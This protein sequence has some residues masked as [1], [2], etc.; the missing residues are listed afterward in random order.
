M[1]DQPAPEHRRP[2][3]VSDATIEALGKL[4]AAVDHVEHARGHLYAFHRLIGSA[5]RT[6]EEATDLL[7]DAGHDA[8]AADLD[9]KVL[10]R[11]P[12]PG[13]WTFQ[14]VEAFDDGYYAEATGLQQRAID[15]LVEGRRHIF[16]AEMKELRR[17]RGIEGHEAT[18]DDADGQI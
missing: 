9:R 4:S 5:E 8:I 15:E 11:N 2:E 6:L 13:M 3:G 16:E 14:M 18:P 17:T 12:L 1:S 10:G 7:R